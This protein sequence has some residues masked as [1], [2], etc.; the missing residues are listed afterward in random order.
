MGGKPSGEGRTSS[1]AYFGKCEPTFQSL[2][3]YEVL[4][5]KEG[6]SLAR[7]SIKPAKLYGRQTLKQVRY[8]IISLFWE[9][10]IFLTQKFKYYH[11]IKFDEK[12]R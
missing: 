1:L 8:I 4:E 11:Q 2:V 6:P 10:L 7:C 12:N 5:S 9:V 3:G